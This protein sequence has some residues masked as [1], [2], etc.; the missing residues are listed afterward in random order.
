ME[1]SSQDFAQADGS[2]RLS[3]VLEASVGPSSG[4]AAPPHTLERILDVVAQRA[5]EPSVRSRGGSFTYEQLLERARRWA[6]AL[7]EVPGSTRVAVALDRS[8]EYLP[9]LLG[10]W[11]CGQSVVPLDVTVP[12][13]RL[14]GLFTDS[15]AQTIVADT[16]PEWAP[17]GVHVVS[18]ASVLETPPTESAPRFSDVA[19]VIFTSGSTGAPKGVEVSHSALSRKIAS[20]AETIGFSAGDLFFAHHAFSADISLK[21]VLMPLTVGGIVYV[22]TGDERELPRGMMEAIRATAPDIMLISPTGARMLV[23]AGWEGRKEMK[24]G[25]G[26]EKLP[27]ELARALRPLVK[28]VTNGYGPTE[29]CIGCMLHVVTDEDLADELASIPIGRPMHDARTY[30]LRSDRTLAGIGE[31]GELAIGGLHLANGYVN[32]A[33]E[34]RAKFV[35]IDVGGQRERVYLSGD[36]VRWTRRWLIEFIG[37]NDHQVKLYGTRIELGEIAAAVTEAQDVREAIADVVDGG[38]VAYLLSDG[39]KADVAAAAAA[40]AR[41]VLPALMRPTHY[42]V[43]AKWPVTSSGKL[44]RQTLRRQLEQRDN[45]GLRRDILALLARDDVPAE[46]RLDDLGANSLFY[47]ALRARLRAN[48]ID[49]DYRTLYAQDTVA[50]LLSLASARMPAHGARSLAATAVEFEKTRDGD[51]VATHTAFEFAAAH[52]NRHVSYGT[53]LLWARFDRAASIRDLR[54]AW[55][56]T[57]T[58]IPVLRAHV[59]GFDGGMRWRVPPDTAPPLALVEVADGTLGAQL[60]RVAD[61]EF[62]RGI[63]PIVGSLIRATLVRERGGAIGVVMAWHRLHIDR[64]SMLRSLEHWCSALSAPVEPC[65]WVV[66]GEVNGAEPTTDFVQMMKKSEPIPSL[67]TLPVRALASSGKLVHS[68]R[69]WIRVAASLGEGV[70]FVPKSEAF[71]N[72]KPNFFDGLRRFASVEPRTYAAQLSPAALDHVREATK[73]LKV[74]VTA[75][76]LGAIAR[77][78]AQWTTRSK[79][80]PAIT[81]RAPDFEV[82]RAVGQLARTIPAVLTPEDD[83]LDSYFIASAR[84]IEVAFDQRHVP[85]ARYTPL[86][87]GLPPWAEFVFNAINHPV[88]EEGRRG[89]TV[90]GARTGPTILTQFCYFDGGHFDVHFDATLVDEQRIRGVLDSATESLEA[91]GQR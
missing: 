11:W 72:A 47:A 62:E 57:C 27:V 1:N 42:V 81:M 17:Q 48:G 76:I 77:A 25:V 82:G 85:V 21:E 41:A 24:L 60:Q 88:I 9:I 58:A 19:Y 36:Q 40:R 2:F 66:S 3:A 74:P 80:Y 52:F 70:K 73:R 39:P 6:T 7:A 56:R 10:A 69:T 83:T 91:L 89:L 71:E 68:V 4:T 54:E 78:V 64:E 49:V 37:R 67:P 5:H 55:R 51:L 43:V 31:A 14:R 26:G 34:T 12:E 61:A 30:V 29:A 18:P 63:D 15:G 45:D 33:E 50:D 35:E 8:S 46:A 59:D 16:S 44:D 32:R 87:P 86:L 90:I 53:E 28:D 65:P 22:A 84:C 20:I 38:I 75:V 23:E 79:V 13:H